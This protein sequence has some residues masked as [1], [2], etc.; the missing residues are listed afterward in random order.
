M[1]G[2]FLPKSDLIPGAA[3]S[4]VLQC[5]IVALSGIDVGVAQHIGYQLD[6]A[7]LAVQVG[8]IGAAQL[9]WGNGF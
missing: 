6:I 1:Y 7:C 4:L 8:A 9:V 3:P 5:G 2:L